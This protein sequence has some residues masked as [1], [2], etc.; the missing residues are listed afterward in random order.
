MQVDVGGLRRSAAISI[1]EDLAAMRQFRAVASN[2][3][4]GRDDIVLRTAGIDYSSYV[5]NAVVLFDHDPSKPIARCV[6]V[7]ARA[8]ELNVLVQFPPE[9][10]S[11]KADEI[12]GLV[13]HGVLNALSI[14][15]DALE[16]RPVKRGSDIVREITKSE[17]AEISVV[18]IPALRSALIT[19]RS[20][21]STD[22][23]R[24]ALKR[25][26]LK[27]GLYEVGS[28]ACLLQDLGW[29]K[30]CAEWEAEFEQD[31][32]SVPAQ[33][34]EALKALGETLI[35]MT[36]EEVGELIGSIDQDEAAPDAGAEA[37]MVEQSANPKIA[38]FRLGMHRRRPVSKSIR[39]HTD[40]RV[41]RRMASLFVRQLGT[42]RP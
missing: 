21:A 18:A 15:F 30:C 5:T 27:R 40:M 19:E 38:R 33:L 4:V 28:L 35:A 32:S 1:D 11:P 9:G 16:S 36:V 26:L 37:D 29:Q 31:G 25:G 2:E 39:A 7:E 8:G 42:A 13:R 14:G 17:L 34:G 12:Y 20:A 23:R 24:E 10:V 3:D 22:P 41:H 6:E